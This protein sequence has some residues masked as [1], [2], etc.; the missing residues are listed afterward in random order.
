[1]NAPADT[2]PET[3]VAVF[4]PESRGR[5]AALFSRSGILPASPE[6]SPAV[7]VIDG[8]S[9]QASLALRLLAASENSCASS[10]LILAVVPCADDAQRFINDGADDF[11]LDG[12]SEDELFLRVRALHERGLKR[13]HFRQLSQCQ[14]S[15]LELTERCAS[16]LRAAPVLSGLTDSLC[17]QL[18]LKSCVLVLVDE[19]QKSAQV[20]ASSG[21]SAVNGMPVSLDGCPEISEALASGRAVP[22]S[23]AADLPLADDVPEDI[24]G[25]AVIPIAVQGRSFGVLLLRAKRGSFTDDELDFALSLARAAAI[26]LRNIRIIE[27]LRDEAASIQDRLQQMSRYEEFF[28]YSSDGIVLLD[29]SGVIVSINPAGE[30]IL[31][32]TPKS[33]VGTPLISLV[34]PAFQELTYEMLLSARNGQSFSNIDIEVNLSGGGTATLWA[35]CAAIQGSGLT[36]LSFRDITAARAD[37]RSLRKSSEFMEKL[38][39][40]SV[41]AVA[42]VSAAGKIILFN[43]SAARTLDRPEGLRDLSTEDVFG[44]ETATRIRGLFALNPRPGEAACTIRPVRTEVLTRSGERVPILL[45]AALVHEGEKPFAAVI[46]FSDL[47]EKARL[48]E[49]LNRAEE[50]L[51]EAQRQALV[52]E[53]AGT[54]AHQLNQPLTCVLGYTDLL[55]KRLPEDDSCRPFAERIR[56]EGERMAD[57]VRKIGR[58]AVYETTQYV[59]TSRIIDLDRASA[60]KAP[61]FTE[62]VISDEPAADEGS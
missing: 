17:E 50:Q 16:S 49:E 23:S 18:S 34:T 39:D 44:D 9:P 60:G 2:L 58:L 43:K 37:E 11:I 40:T 42:A 14:K 3:P 4:P 1:M 41:D 13:R 12:F 28:R 31:E 10:P 33:A 19:A 61:R 25:A 51:A 45:T 27:G 29:G 30:D 56:Q 47:R 35:C 48:E 38:I 21:S 59:G 20:A 57:L 55:L 26:A 15:L 5:F 8:A 7:A 36:F 24:H 22:V 6:S 53:L 54:A 52:A 62:P 32:L 46:I